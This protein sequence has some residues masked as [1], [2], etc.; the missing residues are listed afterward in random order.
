MNIYVKAL[1]PIRGPWG[2]RIVATLD[3]RG[4]SFWVLNKSSFEGPCL[5]KVSQRA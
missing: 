3:K 5:W 2:G 1:G 4:D